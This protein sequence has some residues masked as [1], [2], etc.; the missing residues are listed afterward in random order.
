MR[1]SLLLGL[2][3]S[4]RQSARQQTSAP[5]DQELPTPYPIH[6]I[7]IRC[8]EGTARSS[9]RERP[10]RRRA[11]VE[12]IRTTPRVQVPTKTGRQAAPR[13]TSR[14]G[15]SRSMFARLRRKFS[16]ESSSVPSSRAKLILNEEWSDDHYVDAPIPPEVIDDTE[17]LDL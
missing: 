10:R 13:K 7:E 11:V 4:Q 8:P 2:L 16:E 5:Q 6:R 17:Q 15:H 3:H 9:I 1:P 12:A 14:E